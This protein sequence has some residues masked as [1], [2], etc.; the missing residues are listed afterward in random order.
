MPVKKTT[1]TSRA[2]SD[3]DTA[4]TSHSPRKDKQMGMSFI[5]FLLFLSLAIVSFALYR[6][7]SEQTRLLGVINKLSNEVS[8]Q[9]TIVVPEDSNE[10]KILY[11]DSGVQD[12]RLGY[13][14][15]PNTFTGPCDDLMIYRLDQNGSKE[16]LVPSVRKLEGAPLTTELLQ[17]LAINKDGSRIAFGAW[18]YGSERNANDKR[19]WIMETSSGKLI[20]QSNL[21][22]TES[23]YSPNMSYAAYYNVTED[24]EEQIMVVDLLAE[25]EF[26]AARATGGIMYKD[27]NSKATINWLNDNTIAI[28]QYEMAEDGSGPTI[29]GEREITIN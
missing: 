16:V 25:K 27:A 9:Q 28:I 8:M 10:T 23:V 14:S 29:V 17:P 22:P 5:I 18:A 20:A 11:S 2:K 4:H 12:L 1:K 19:I 26:L 24:G 3:Q 13:T 6:V 7:Y 21:V 15:C